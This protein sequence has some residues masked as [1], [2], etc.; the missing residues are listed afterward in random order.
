MDN[1]RRF[2]ENGAPPLTREQNDGGSKPWHSRNR[3]INIS[4]QDKQYAPPG[5]ADE[6]I[7]PTV[8]GAGAAPLSSQPAHDV[9][10]EYMRSAPR[11][12]GENNP[13][14][15]TSPIGTQVSSD[16]VALGPTVTETPIRIAPAP[17]GHTE[18]PT[19]WRRPE[20]VG[21]RSLAQESGAMAPG[22]VPLRI[23]VADNSYPAYESVTQVR[24]AGRFVLEY[25]GHAV[26]GAFA[27]DI[28][29]AYRPDI[30]LLDHSIP[31]L[32]AIS[33]VRETAVSSPGTVVIAAIP[34]NEGIAM[35][36]RTNGVPFLVL[37]NYANPV[38]PFNYDD[39]AAVFSQAGEYIEQYFRG[40]RQNFAPAAPAAISAPAP[41]TTWGAFENQGAVQPVLRPVEPAVQ[42]APAPLALAP[43]TPAPVVESRVLDVRNIVNGGVPVSTGGDLQTRARVITTYSVKGGCGK[44]TLTTNLA[45]YAAENASINGRKPK[46]LFIEADMYYCAVDTFLY[47]RKKELRTLADLIKLG[48]SPERRAYDQSVL[49]NTMWQP[50]GIDNLWIISGPALPSETDI[51]TD[52]HI[53]VLVETMAPRFDYIFIDTSCDLARGPILTSMELADEVLLVVQCN[54]VATRN[55]KSLLLMLKGMARDATSAPALLLRKFRAVINMA[56]ETGEFNSPYVRQVL[57]SAKP[58][59]VAEFVIGEIPFD[60]KAA[61][62][63]LDQGQ[64]AILSHP[65]S[66]LAQGVAALANKLGIRNVNSTKSTSGRNNQLAVIN[67]DMEEP[68]KKKKGLFGF[69]GGLFTRKGKSAPTPKKPIKNKLNRR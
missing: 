11:F 37:K 51:V 8:H 66:R 65:D 3:S 18:T 5:K 17:H 49:E 53:I 47:S 33:V 42:P 29:R 64:P 21:N 40:T 15:I 25:V 2:G 60:R 56:R 55:T 54:V 57:D 9:M 14:P 26:T 39:L 69:L 61:E 63:A 30:L 22:L 62:E 4:R 24:Q 48:Y 68:P 46:V 67:E 52:D 12:T 43:I 32:D 58:E 36:M 35:Q 28:L 7:E 45:S 23:L 31:V 6:H 50:E 38:Q 10:P 34:N 16:F 20:P 27:L 59:G 1:N 19:T 44:T 13:S 41:A